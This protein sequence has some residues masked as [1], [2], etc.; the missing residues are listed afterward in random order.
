MGIMNQSRNAITAAKL[1]FRL[2]RR[3]IYRVWKAV[4]LNRAKALISEV[5]YKTTRSSILATPVIFLSTFEQPLDYW[6][7][8]YLF[9]EEELTFVCPKQLPSEGISKHLRA[10]N[11]I[12]F[13]D[14]KADFRFLRQFL[15]ILRNFNRSIVISPQAAEKYIGKFSIDPVVIVR[16]A[17]MAN[18]PIVPVIMAWHNKKCHIE[19]GAR[20]SISPRSEEFKDVFFKRRGVRKYRSLPKDDLN[21]IGRRIFAKLKQGDD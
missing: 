12:L 11:H 17:M 9:R 7:L 13:F 5:R 14:K 4:V 16:I 18:V 19:V 20:V 3:V 1:R 6:I 21:E 15:S 2:F 10:V 8:S